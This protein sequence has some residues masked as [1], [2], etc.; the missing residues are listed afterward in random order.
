MAFFEG[1]LT[2]GADRINGVLARQPLD[3]DFGMVFG[4]LSREG[5]G[6]PL[7][8]LPDCGMREVPRAG[9]NFRSTRGIR[10]VTSF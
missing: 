3:C 1:A 2:K 6:L 8:M 4:L 5:F 10:E 7:Q 9:A